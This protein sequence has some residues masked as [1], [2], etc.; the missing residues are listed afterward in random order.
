MAPKF[1][2]DPDDTL[3]DLGDESDEF[4]ETML[5]LVEDGTIV[6]TCDGC[7]QS[8]TPEE[9]EAVECPRCGEVD[10]DN[11]LFTLPS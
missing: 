4:D 7:K 9:F 8:V 3:R 5:M 10:L 1:L 2:V 6:A 11:F